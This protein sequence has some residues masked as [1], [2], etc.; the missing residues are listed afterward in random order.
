MAETV[1][2]SKPLSQALQLDRQTLRIFAQP[3][4][5]YPSP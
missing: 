4:S 5:Q 3:Q 2:V 1:S